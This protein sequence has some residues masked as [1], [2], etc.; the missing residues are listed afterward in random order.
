MG[1][2][3]DRLAVLD[4]RLRVRGV[5]G[6]RVGDLSAMPNINASNTN[7]PALMME[8]DAPSSSWPGRSSEIRSIGAESGI[9]PGG[10]EDDLTTITKSAR[11]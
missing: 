5:E 9:W 11:K 2:T 1:S 7:A 10:D 6:L 3:G 4:P 8:A